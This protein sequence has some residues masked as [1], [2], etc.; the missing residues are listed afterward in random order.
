MQPSVACAVSDQRRPGS[1]TIEGDTEIVN[2]KSI[3]TFPAP[4]ILVALAATGCEPSPSPPTGSVV[5]S[6]GVRI[7]ELGPAPLDL[8]ERILAVEPDL[9]IRS[10]EDDGASVLS[11][12]RDV[13]VLSN[14]RIA[15][16]NGSGNNIQ[17]FDAAGQHIGTWGGRGDGP[18]EF[19]YLEWLASLPPDSLAAGDSGLRRVAIFDA[20]GRYVRNSSTTSAVDPASRP[21]PPRPMGLLADG[22]MIAASFGRPEPVEGTAR[23]PVEIVT[24][25]PSGTGAHLL[26]T[27]PGEELAIFEQDGSLQV[28]QAPFGRRVHIAT[29][30]DAVWIADDEQ[31]EVRQYSARGVLRMNCPVFRRSRTGHR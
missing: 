8:V 30:P 15:V 7:V 23:P 28:T 2:R 19:R 4:A 11:D 17:V 26:G 21:I 3:G 10:G 25:P 13:E 22:S 16:V 9:V 20:A 24:I 1:A 18:G 6:A 31:W 12:V 14:G 29:A 27:W 5:D